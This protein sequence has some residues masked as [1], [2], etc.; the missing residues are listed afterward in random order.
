[1]RRDGILEII[2]EHCLSTNFHTL[3]QFCFKFQ[4]SDSSKTGNTNKIKR[5]NEHTSA[6][7]QLVSSVESCSWFSGSN[8]ERTC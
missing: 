4:L 7:V 1:M 3:Q 6:N 5:L 8:S 2:S